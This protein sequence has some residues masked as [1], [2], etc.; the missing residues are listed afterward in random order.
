MIAQAEAF[1]LGAYASGINR[2]LKG[3]LK[4]D[5]DAPYVVHAPIWDKWTWKGFENKYV[6]IGAM[7]RR[8]MHSNQHMRIY[9]ASGYY[10]LATPHAAGAYTLAHLGLRG[11]QFRK[12]SVSYFEAGHMMCIHAPSLARMAGE[13]RAF[14]GAA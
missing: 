8:A 10:D 1:A 6:S 11:E 9:V 12:I 3:T 5:D 14:V 2:V 4:Y 7:L 13:L